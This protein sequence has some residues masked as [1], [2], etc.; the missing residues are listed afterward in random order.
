[1][2][3]TEIRNAEGAE[4]TDAVRQWHGAAWAGQ[5]KETGEPENPPGARDCVAVMASDA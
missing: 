4:T 3:N 1:L 5:S 2:R